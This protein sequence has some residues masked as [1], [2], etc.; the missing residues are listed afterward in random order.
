MPGTGTQ[1]VNI[2]TKKLDVLRYG[3]G[4]LPAACAGDELVRLT[5]AYDE[6]FASRAGHDRGDHYDLAGSND[7]TDRLS[8]PQI[9]TPH[10]YISFL[11]QSRLWVRCRDFANEL[12][13]T[14]AQFIEDHA[15]LKPARY[16]SVTPW[17]QDEAYWDPGRRHITVN[18]WIPLQ[19][20]TPESGCLHYIP[21]SHLWEVLEHQPIGNDPRTHGLELTDRG[22]HDAHLERA[23]AV[24]CAAGDAVIHFPRSVHYAGPNLTDRDRRAYICSFGIPAETITSMR[25]FPWL[26]RRKTLREQRAA[27]TQS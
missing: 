27:A 5:A 19:D 22:L 8:L 3:Y 25:S 10:K 11:T 23:R 15:I 20:A 1:K 24:P 9:M 21:G 13:G 16:G 14:E 6:M 17:H 26:E 2:P 18:F 12:L 4:L 7:E